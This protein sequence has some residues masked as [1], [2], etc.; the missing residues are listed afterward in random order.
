MR[1]RLAQHEPLS[2]DGPQVEKRAAVSVILREQGE[3]SGPEV[4]LM[5]RATSTRDPWSGHMSFPGGRHEPH[6]TDL[7]ATAQR[8]TLEEVGLDLT[9][10]G[11]PLGRLDDIEAV[12]RALRTGMIIRPYVFEVPASAELRGNYEVAELVW[13]PL[14]PLFMGE[15]NIT[16]DY[17]LAGRSLKLP[18]YD[19]Q[20]RVV[21]GLTHQMLASFFMLLR[22]P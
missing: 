2:L 4:L 7:S 8:E 22:Q 15:R 13:A 20:G 12:A 10:H 6:D 9:T 19:V 1:Q 16:H 21:W 5:R 17:E 3:V 11:T 18:A 14:R